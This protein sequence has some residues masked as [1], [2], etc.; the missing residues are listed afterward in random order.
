MNNDIYTWNGKVASK[1]LFN[2]LS[3]S[4]TRKWYKAYV[5]HRLF[6][7]WVYTNM[8]D[9]SFLVNNNVVSAIKVVK[10]ANDCMLFI[11]LQMPCYKYNFINVHSLTKN[12]DDV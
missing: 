8:F 3:V 7:T 11:V 2:P 10:F 1:H 4:P 6:L 9:T 12:K 5:S